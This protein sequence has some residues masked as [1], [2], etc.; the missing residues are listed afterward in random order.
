MFSPEAQS[1]FI[2]LQSRAS[3]TT[4][5]Y[6]LERIDRALDEILRNA[7][8]AD[9]APFQIR[10]ALA[11]ASKVIANRRTVAP[12]CSIDDPAV[13]AGAVDGQ[14]DAVDLMCWLATTPLTTSI[15]DILLGLATGQEASTLAAGAGIPVPRMRE[16][17]SRA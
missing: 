2:A 9:P 10:S 11:N 13:E 12:T 14:Y 3:K 16:K 4:D 17:I 7:E 8:K 1:A 6:G 15:R 5:N